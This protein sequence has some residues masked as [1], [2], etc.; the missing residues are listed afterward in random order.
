MPLVSGSRGE[1]RNSNAMDP[2]P[3]QS[4]F[5]SMHELEAALEAHRARGWQMELAVT[6]P[7]TTD[8][9][10]VIVNVEDCE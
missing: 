7:P 3:T 5:P 9:D 2:D 4:W 10:S 8:P 1:R 6:P